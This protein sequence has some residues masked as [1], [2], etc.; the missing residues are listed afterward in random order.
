MYLCT[1]MGGR[2][3]WI[4]GVGLA[5]ENIQTC[6]LKAIKPDS[7]HTVIC[8]NSMI[9][10]QHA[11][12]TQL[13][14]YAKN[15]KSSHFSQYEKQFLLRLRTHSPPN[16]TTGTTKYCICKCRPQAKIVLFAKNFRTIADLDI[17]IIKRAKIYSLL[18]DNLILQLQYQISSSD[19]MI[20]QMET[21]C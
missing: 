15:G 13:Q 16:C 5:P 21:K 4:I 1:S 7:I 11:S 19:S 17:F 6:L 12:G 18:Q 3:K 8:V 20:Y 14:R 9:G 2:K 10:K